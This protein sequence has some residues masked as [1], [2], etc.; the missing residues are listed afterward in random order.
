[1]TVPV[2]G[3]TSDGF[4]LGC[5]VQVALEPSLGP[6]ILWFHEHIGLRLFM[7]LKGYPPRRDPHHLWLL[8]YVYIYI[9]LY[10]LS[11]HVCIYIY[12]TSYKHTYTYLFNI[13]FLGPSLSSANGLQPKHLIS[14]LKA[15]YHPYL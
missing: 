6:N 12:L 15:S 14:P 2:S 11:I 3:G 7:I 5:A 10:I 1:M 4:P 8:M 9:Y 13:S